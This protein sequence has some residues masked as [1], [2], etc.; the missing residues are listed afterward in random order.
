V[1]RGPLGQSGVFAAFSLIVLSE[2][3]DKTFFIAAILAARLGRWIA[4][5]GSVAALSVMTG[6]SV[7]IG[8]IC[9]R[10]P[11][12]MRSTLPLGEIAG[13]LLLILF[14]L[15]ALR[16]CGDLL[17]N[18]PATMPFKPVF[19]SAAMNCDSLSDLCDTTRHKSFSPNACRLF[20]GCS[21][22]RMLA[23]VWQGWWRKGKGH[24]EDCM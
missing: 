18:S 9:A 2:I 14:G 12:A 6:V 22:A 19:V 4:F 16:V 23:G 1:A 7:A 15:R 13:C 20:G 5:V 17:G 10:V 8:A 11:D 21:A 24:A 3:G